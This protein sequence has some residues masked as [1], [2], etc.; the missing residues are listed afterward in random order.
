VER[1]AVNEQVDRG[2]NSREGAPGVG[3]RAWHRYFVY[4]SL[5]FVA[6][7]LY[8][9]DY[10]RVP[11]VTSYP[12]LLASYV[13]QLCGFLLLVA[14]W[15][16]VQARSG[17]PVR[18]ADGLA[19][20]G[21]SIFGS[22]LPGKIWLIVGRAGY[23]AQRYPYP[24][25]KLSVLS[26]HA[27]LISLWAGLLVGSLG[28]FAIHGL[29]LWGPL[30]LALWLALTLTIFSGVVHAMVARLASR[31]L[32]RKLTIP[33]LS[34]RSTTLAIAWALAAWGAWA[35]AFYLLLQA[36][37]MAELSPL[38]GLAFPLAATLGIV[39]VI[40]PGGLGA[41]EGVLVGYLVLAGQTAAVATTTAVAARLWFMLGELLLFVLA[42]FTRRRSGTTGQT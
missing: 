28:A 21:L 24:F 7:I 18:F 14:S 1:R 22:Y 32:K 33:L 27:Q 19:A 15:T 26:L 30:I 12:A 35:T 3:G 11:Q 34:F 29:S 8:R 16:V 20:L 13:L 39:A 9:F 25:T 10:L 4:L 6:V 36:L 40:A 23:I 5:I 41:R 42:W 2:D 17:C 38:Y 31:W 37:G